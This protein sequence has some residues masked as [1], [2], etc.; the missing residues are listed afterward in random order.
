MVPYVYE[1]RAQGPEGSFS[2]PILYQ[3]QDFE[4]P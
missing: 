4:D 1:L 3:E 2:K